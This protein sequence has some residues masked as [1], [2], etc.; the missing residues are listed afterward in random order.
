MYNWPSSVFLRLAQVCCLRYKSPIVKPICKSRADSFE[1]IP[2]PISKGLPCFWWRS[3][4]ISMVQT[5]ASEWIDPLTY[6]PT[7]VSQHPAVWREGL[8]TTKSLLLGPFC[9]VSLLWKGLFIYLCA[10]QVGY[11]EVSNLSFQSRYWFSV[12][13]VHQP[14]G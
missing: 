3:H 6:L 5:K 1:G 9:P 7:S 4:D 12:H 11:L 2:V 8:W 13:M 10:Q 14:A